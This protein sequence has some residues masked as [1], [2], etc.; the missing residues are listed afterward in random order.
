M[1]EWWR[2][3]QRIVQTNLALTDADM[4]CREVARDI[5]KFGATAV[6]FNVGG[7][8]AWYPTK[9][10]LQAVNPFLKSDIVGEM[11]E[12]C[13]AENIKFIGRFDLSKA[14]RLAYD[15]HPEW[16]CH[17]SDGKPF[18]YNGTYQAS[19]T[20]G[21]YHDY[22]LKILTET[23]STYEIDAAFFN[24]FGYSRF[25]YSH[26][27]FGFSHDPS[28]VKRFAEFADG[29]R[30]PDANDPSDPAYKK[31]L[32]F[33]DMT[34]AETSKLIYEHCKSV[35]P[36]IGIANLNGGRDWIR[37]ESNRSSVRPQPEWV[38]QTGELARQAQSIGRGISP[39]TVAQTHYFDFPWRQTSESA[40]FQANRVAQALA[41]GAEPHYFFMG[42]I[43]RQE[44]TKAV[45]VIRDF[46]HYHARNEDLYD[47][48]DSA[49]RIGL[50]Q[51]RAS[52]RF[53]ETM[54][55]RDASSHR[56][57]N[58][59]R[60]AYRALVESNL[61]FDLIADQLGQA[62]D[63][64]DILSRYEVIV[65]ADASCLGD[66]E[67]AAFDAYVEQGGNLVVTGRTGMLTR[68]GEERSSVALKSL[69]ITGIREI[70]RDIV[71]AYF[72][73]ATDELDF[74][75]TRSIMLRGTYLF[76]EQKPDT[77]TLLRMLPP[78]KFGPPE[79]CYP[80]EPV[81]DEP[82]VIIGRHGRGSVA[83]LPWSPDRLYHAHSLV[84]HRQIIAQLTQRF[85]PPVAKLARG[86][87]LELTVRR[88]SESGETVVHLVNYSGQ[89]NDNFD[90]PVVQHGLRLG[91]RNAGAGPVRALVAGASIDA[92][93]PD[94]DGY[95]WVDV[96]PVGHMEALV[97]P[98]AQG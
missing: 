64:L 43:A 13:R 18:E 7:I 14:T 31:Y 37:M 45:P 41:N 1:N 59:F 69:P 47:T 19:L 9:L 54:R 49:A 5:R 79:L 51:S 75:D 82:G 96:P 23:L 86:S 36:S 76:T 63:F 85:S 24:F 67:A 58:A 6:F 94:A 57:S 74:P 10:P 84:E 83:Y 98:A 29:A 17:T 12:A 92:S 22:A 48:L 80:E 33:Q 95:R 35:R 50:Y 8:Y 46:M 72:K 40:A 55:L 28:A 89:S 27:D 15:A 52:D 26:H 30:I 32:A 91:V 3:P 16:F 60:G 93:E 97:F 11:I 88:S 38:Y 56:S 39:Y 53:G 66:Q 4:D 34:S 61:A 70:R 90:E 42:P 2:E 62:A 25:N 78:Q 81:S 71:A 65:L 44:D 87:R 73:V 20:G 68:T 77:E 21:W